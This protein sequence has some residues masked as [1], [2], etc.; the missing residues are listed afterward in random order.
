MLQFPLLGEALSDTWNI[1]L[2]A[3]FHMTNDSH[4][5]DQEYAEGRL[6]LYEGKM[7]PQF[8]NEFSKPRYWINE[9]EGRKA[10]L[11][12]GRKDD[13]QL[14]NY[15]NY[16]LSF[17]DIAS[18][19]NERTMIATIT[20]PSFHGNKCPGIRVVDDDNKLLITLPEQL[21]LCAMLNSFV[22]DSMF[23][24]RVSTT[25]NF[26]YVYQTPIPRLTKTDQPFQKIVERAAKL[27]C[28]TPEFDDLAAEVGL[29]SHTN[30]ITDE[31]Q[32]AQLRAELDGII[33][34]LYHLTETEFAHILQT[35]PIVPEATKIMA[36]NAYRDVERGLI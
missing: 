35:F 5:F 29:G 24:N 25:L 9:V 28:T 16:L 23:K 19:T 34:H 11:K 6:P 36:L 22:V 1:K 17:R 8:T 31:V 18:S 26:F 27:I 4:L 21:Y 30:G 20:P 10:L 15:Q 13:S 33:A 12:K 7:I 32:R 14:M 3:E 2:T